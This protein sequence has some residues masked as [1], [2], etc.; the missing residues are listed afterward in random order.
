MPKQSILMMCVANSA[1]SQMAEALAKTLAP[2]GTRIFSAGSNP[3]RLNPFAAAALAARGISS[4]EL[5]SKGLNDIP[6]S[7]IDCVITLCA[8]EVCP[9]FPHRTQRLHWPLPDPAALEGTDDQI[10]ASFITVRN[11]IERRLTVFFAQQ[12]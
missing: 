9:M 3:D 8:E 12:D 1:R 11:E 6:Q 4:D 5:H 10:L 7:E 2:E